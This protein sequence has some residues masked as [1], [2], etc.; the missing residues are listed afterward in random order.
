MD[1]HVLC[2]RSLAD[3]PISCLHCARSMASLLRYETRARRP[4]VWQRP[5]TT[6]AWHRKR[7]VASPRASR[8]LA[9]S[10]RRAARVCAQTRP[11]AAGRLIPTRA[12]ERG[13]VVAKSSRQVVCDQVGIARGPEVCAGAHHIAHRFNLVNEPSGGGRYRSQLRADGMARWPMGDGYFAFLREQASRCRRLAQQV[14]DDR[15]HA[16]LAEWR[17]STRPVPPNW[18]RRSPLPRIRPHSTTRCGGGRV[19]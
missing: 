11:T 13:A 5:P 4:T 6:V 7:G 14:T 12:G 16:I 17:T 19:R 18:K 1:S 3:G 9:G 2:W 15:A 10:G 8:L